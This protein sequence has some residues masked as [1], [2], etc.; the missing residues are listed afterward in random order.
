MDNEVT[1]KKPRSLAELDYQILCERYGK[2][3]A[4]EI[5]KLA[6]ALHEASSIRLG[7]KERRDS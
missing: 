7:L 1:T 3:D 4:I 6:N 5:M 2:Q